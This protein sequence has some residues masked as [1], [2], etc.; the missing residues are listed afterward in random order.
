ML[1]FVIKAGIIAVLLIVGGSYARE[2]VD[3]WNEPCYAIATEVGPPPK[4]VLKAMKRCGPNY[5]YEYNRLTKELKVN[6]DGEW[7]KLRY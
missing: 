2:L 4:V 3:W 6:I 7:L 1:R 5:V